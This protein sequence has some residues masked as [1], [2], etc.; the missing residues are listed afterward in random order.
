MMSEADDTATKVCDAMVLEHAKR[1]EYFCCGEV[2]KYPL[3]DTVWLERQ[4]KD[5]LSRQ[6]QQSWYLPGVTSRNIGQ[7]VYVIQMGNNKTLERGH[8]QLLPREPDPHGRAATI[9]FRR[10]RRGGRVHR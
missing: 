4:H 9:Q 10:R 1:A 8:T 5:I 7:D 6:R 3:R 2:H